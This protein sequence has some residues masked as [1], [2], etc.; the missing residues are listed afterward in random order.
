MADIIFSEMILTLLYTSDIA[1]ILGIHKSKKA[2]KHS[3]NYEIM[4]FKLRK[5][6][7]APTNGILYYFP[8]S[9]PLPPV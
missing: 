8:H 5:I 6:V 7:K 4:N 1:V 2:S 3:P 9:L